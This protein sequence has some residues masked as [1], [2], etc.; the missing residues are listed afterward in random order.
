MRVQKT[1]A[2]GA[3]IILDKSSL[4]LRAIILLLG[5][6]VTLNLL[7]INGW[8]LV[9]SQKSDCACMFVCLKVCVHWDTRIHISV[10]KLQRESTEYYRQQEVES[11][12]TKVRVL[13]IWRTKHRANILNKSVLIT[14]WL[15][16]QS[17]I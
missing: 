3:L 9:A 10:L 1:P 5:W 16:L 2:L 11:S 14:L 8:E 7:H 4:L 15:F 17:D 13:L 12:N 6:F